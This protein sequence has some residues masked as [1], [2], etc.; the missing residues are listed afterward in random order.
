MRSTAFAV[1]LWW[2]LLDEADFFVGFILPAVPVL[3]GA[4]VIWNF[5]KEG[6]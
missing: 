5:A 4:I 3:Y 2:L 1:Y 6:F